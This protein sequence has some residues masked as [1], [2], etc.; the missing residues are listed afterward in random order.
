M[1]GRRGD[2]EI[3]LHVALGR[4]LAVDLHISP[5]E[6]EVLAVFF[7]EAGTRRR[8]PAKY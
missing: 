7:G 4:R 2:A 8:L 3:A 6:G 1:D 5:D